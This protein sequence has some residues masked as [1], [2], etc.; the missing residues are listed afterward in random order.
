MNLLDVTNIGDADIVMLETE[1]P[2]SS[3]KKL[4]GL[5]RCMK[6]GSR[7]LS[8]IDVNSLVNSGSSVDF[9]RFEHN[10]SSYDRISTS[11][12][13]HRGHHFYL[14]AKVCFLFGSTV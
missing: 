5:L 6:T 2:R 14:W 11:W 13:M 1:I 3:H 7:L 9:R 12:S 10:Q 4:W 8:Y